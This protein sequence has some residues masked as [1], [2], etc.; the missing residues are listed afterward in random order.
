M[1]ADETR[2][3]SNADETRPFSNADETREYLFTTLKED[4]E[5]A[6]EDAAEAAYVADLEGV[7]EDTVHPQP[8]DG[9]DSCE[10]EELQRPTSPDIPGRDEEAA[11]R[12]RDANAASWNSKSSKTFC[13]EMTTGNDDVAS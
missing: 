3:F 10:E 13:Y 12:M 7:P 4:E 6:E 1:G 11:L 5:D 2:P 9:G 8:V